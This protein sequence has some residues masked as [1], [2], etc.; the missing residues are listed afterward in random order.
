M[1]C[2]KRRHRMSLARVSA[3]LLAALQ[4]FCSSHS[5]LFFY[6]VGLGPSICTK[7]ELLGTS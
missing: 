5:P 6:H 1:W 2:E 3:G 4:F 7:Q